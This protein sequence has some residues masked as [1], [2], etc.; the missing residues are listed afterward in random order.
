MRSK[1]VPTNALTPVGGFGPPLRSGKLVLRQN[2]KG[3]LITEPRKVT[4]RLG[5]A[6]FALAHQVFW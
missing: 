6:A 2:S 1:I 5:P 4:Q 3:G